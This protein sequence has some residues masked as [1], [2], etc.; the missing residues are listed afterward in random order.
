L[1][2]VFAPYLGGGILV[3]TLLQFIQKPLIFGKRL[4]EDGLELLQQ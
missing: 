2:Q 4:M 3:T 1:A